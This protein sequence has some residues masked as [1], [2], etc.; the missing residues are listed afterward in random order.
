MGIRITALLL[1]LVATAASGQACKVIDP[2]LQVSYAGPCVNGLAEGVGH[3]FGT[4]EYRGGFK[5]GKKHGKGVKTWANGDRYEGD[6]FDD[7][8]EGT[9]AYVWGRGPW[10]GERYEGAYLR[11]RRHGFGTYRY[12]SGDVYA[13]PWENDIATGPPTPMMLALR[14]FQE[15]ARSAVAK[16]GVKVCRELPIGI[17]ERDWIRGTVVAKKDERVGIRIDDAGRYPHVVSN[18]E[19][20]KGETIWDAPTEWTPCF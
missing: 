6:F 2:E 17:A 8:K 5:A 19:I 10:Q 3:A 14:K 7:F 11:D 1:A 16:E 4:A 15:E 12:A 20:R 13:G 9:G 18:V